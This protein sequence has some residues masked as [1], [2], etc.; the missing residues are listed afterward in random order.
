MNVKRIIHIGAAVKD[1]EKAKEILSGLFGL[2]VRKE[3]IYQDE[4]KLCFLPVGDS[5]IELFADKNTDGPVSKIIENQGGEGIHHIA[6]EV[7]DID[8]AVEEIKER[9]LPLID[10]TPKP[11]AHGTRI[12]YIDPSATSG[13]LIEL[14]QI[15]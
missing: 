1:I 9:G 2:P 11:G 15:I 3:E 13:M 4:I 14:V 8:G 5:Q 7:D 6:L 12:A 10:E